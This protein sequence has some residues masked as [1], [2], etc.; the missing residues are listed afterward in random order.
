MM[1]SMVDEERTLGDAEGWNR[2]Y[3]EGTAKWDLGEAPPVLTDHIARRGPPPAERRR[4]LVPGAGYGHDAMAWARAGWAVTAV[5][6]APLAVEGM[7]TR[8]ANAGLDMQVLEA[9]V[10]DLPRALNA[11][12]DL[13]WEQTC[14]CALYPEMRDAY[15]ASMARAIKPTGEYQALFWNHG[16]EGG[17]PY[18]I[19]P[20]LVDRLFTPAFEV[21]ENR[22]VPPERS[23]RSH[24]FLSL[25]RPR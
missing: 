20:D 22:P 12:F 5:D 1:A 21:L 16:N 2:R 19:S 25:M 23:R 7:Q 24:E 13:I 8:A 14:L 10:L 4:V 18:D 3:A 6:F 11:A 9:D 17:P 15:V